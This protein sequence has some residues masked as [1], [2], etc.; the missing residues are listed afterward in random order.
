[1]ERLEEFFGGEED[2]WDAGFESDMLKDFNLEPIHRVYHDGGTIE[3]KE[4]TG[5]EHAGRVL[6]IMASPSDLETPI[7]IDCVCEGG[8][9]YAVPIILDGWHRYMAHRA[10]SLDKIPVSF[11]G[12]VDLAEYL[13]GDADELPE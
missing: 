10:L 2:P 4:W 3:R 8:R 5:K 1:M 12:R 9:I 7:E 11:G 6:A 13:R